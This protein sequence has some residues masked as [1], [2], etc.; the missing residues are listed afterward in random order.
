MK[1][2]EEDLYDGQV[3]QK[4]L[5]ERQDPTTW[6][7]PPCP[8]NSPKLGLYLL[9]GPSCGFFAVCLSGFSAG[10]YVPSHGA[11]AGFSGCS[12]HGPRKQD[13]ERSR[14]PHLISLATLVL[15]SYEHF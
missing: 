5:G 12:C 4:L 9:G 1:Q 11:A 8:G 7:H 15:S 3:L 14:V 2:L 6:H 10:R 13:S